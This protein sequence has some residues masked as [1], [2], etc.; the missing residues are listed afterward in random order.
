MTNLYYSN[1]NPNSNFDGDWDAACIYCGRPHKEHILTNH[2]DPNY[3]H[4][5][6]CEQQKEVIRREQRRTVTMASALMLVGWIIVPLAIGVLGF[7]SVW[8][9]AFLFA[10]WLLSIGWRVVKLFGHP[11]KWF[12]GYKEKQEKELRTRHYFYH[13]ERNPEGFRRLREENFEKDL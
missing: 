6:P 12:P 11:E 9:G 4:R 5:V 7:A 13:C 10:L 8:F 2:P 3:K 1:K